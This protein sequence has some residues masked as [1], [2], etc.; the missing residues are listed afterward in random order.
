MRIP[1]LLS[2]VISSTF[3]GSVHANYYNT[4]PKGV[5]LVAYRHVRTSTVKSSY[6]RA[7]AE[8]P[9]NYKIDANISLLEGF[10][11]LKPVLQEFKEYNPEA[12]TEL[13]MGKYEID[14]SADVQVDGYGIGYGVT[15][16]LT[17]YGSIPIY[18]AKVNIDYERIKGN[19]FREVSEKYEANGGAINQTVGDAL[20]QLPDVNSSALQNAVVDTL[21]YD[22]IGDWEGSGLGDIEIGAIY[23]LTNNGYR[24]TAVSF[25]VV[26]PT[27]YVDDPD[28][29]QDI[30]FGD[31]QWDIFGEVGGG[32]QLNDSL[33]VNSFTRY[34][35]QFASQKKLRV[36]YDDEI[37]LSDETGTFEEKLGNKWQ[38]NLESTWT[39]ND[40]FALTPAY[41]F[42]Y[43]E[44]AQYRSKYKE[45][46]AYLA[47][48]TDSEAHNFRVTGEIS[49]ITPFIKKK[50]MLPASI[51]L[52]YQHMLRGKNTS[53]VDRYEIEFRMMF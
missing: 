44:K 22:E 52:M 27:G 51:R 30:G 36:P 37:M 32:I 31:G 40:W 45:A 5:R 35:Y 17:M 13:S 39:I 6:N 24:G 14:A 43:Q 48:N 46:N 47:H 41:V 15:N 8:T 4:L 38:F 2:L 7:N 18:Q 10:D 12:Y 9:F 28:I 49:S 42:D 1:K 20:D 34:T 53:K 29:I 3:I 16:K 50:F 21:G 25:G 19:N 23:N 11:S 26:A 33:A